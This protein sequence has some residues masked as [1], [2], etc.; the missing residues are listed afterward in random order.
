MLDFVQKRQIKQSVLE[1][2][3][4]HGTAYVSGADQRDYVKQLI[5][6]GDIDLENY[7][8]SSMGYLQLA[9]KSPV[10]TRKSPVVKQAPTPKAPKV[11]PVARKVTSKGITIPQEVL[12]ALRIPEH[13]YA[14]V[15]VRPI[16]VYS[17]LVMNKRGTN[18]STVGV[19]RQVDGRVNINKSVLAGLGFAGRVGQNVRIAPNGRTGDTY[20]VSLA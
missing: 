10:K 15:Y 14:S 11:D 12:T 17:F 7:E 4:R 16:N 1:N 6:L 18:P 13:S 8:L 19:F 20:I 2:I 5:Q 9:K 3:R